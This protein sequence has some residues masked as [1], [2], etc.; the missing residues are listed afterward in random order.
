MYLDRRIQSRGTKDH[1]DHRCSHTV[2][3]R[4]ESEINR[5]CSTSF[6]TY[7]IMAPEIGDLRVP[8][9]MSDLLNLMINIYRILFSEKIDLHI[10]NGWDKN[11][12]VKYEVPIK[13]ALPMY[14]LALIS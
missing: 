8:Q 3:I 10:A 7:F 12:H 4:S 13:G 2:V 14:E 6:S 11:V 1:C 5:A 9:R